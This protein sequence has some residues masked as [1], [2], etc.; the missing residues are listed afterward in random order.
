MFSYFQNKIIL[1]R[2]KVKVHIG[3][4]LPLDGATFKYSWGVVMG[5]V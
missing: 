5:A 1:I 3:M 2:L 4:V